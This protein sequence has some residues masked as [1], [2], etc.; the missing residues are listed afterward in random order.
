MKFFNKIFSKKGGQAIAEY[1]LV[2]LI[3][4][5]AAAAINT[6]YHSSENLIKELSQNIRNKNVANEKNSFYVPPNA[7]L[8]NT[9]GTE[10]VEDNPLIASGDKKTISTSPNSIVEPDQ[11]NQNENFVMKG[12]HNPIAYF[13]TNQPSTWDTLSVYDYS[14]DLDGGDASKLKRFWKFEK[15]SNVNSVDDNKNLECSHVKNCSPGSSGIWD[16]RSTTNATYKNFTALGGKNTLTYPSKRDAELLSQGYCYGTVHQCLPTNLS[17]GNYSIHLIVIDEDQNEAPEAI[18]TITVKSQRLKLQYVY[19]YGEEKIVGKKVVKD[20]GIKEVKLIDHQYALVTDLYGVK[21]PV[22]EMNMVRT[23]SNKTY[24]VK[25]EQKIKTCQVLVDPD[26][27][28]EKGE[29]TNCKIETVEQTKEVQ[30]GGSAGFDKDEGNLWKE[31]K[32]IAND[33][34]FYIYDKRSLFNKKFLGNNN[35]NNLNLTKATGDLDGKVT[36]GQYTNGQGLSS[37]KYNSLRGLTQPAADEIVWS[38]NKRS[39]SNMTLNNS[40]IDAK[41]LGTNFQTSQMSLYSSSPYYPYEDKNSNLANRVIGVNNTNYNGNSSV[42]TNSYADTSGTQD[43]F[44]HI[45]VKK[46]H[47]AISSIAY[48]RKCIKNCNSQN[49]T[50]VNKTPDVDIIQL[51]SSYYLLSQQP[52]TKNVEQE[53]SD[54]IYRDNTPDFSDGSSMYLLRTNIEQATSHDNN[55]SPDFVSIRLSLNDFYGYNPGANMDTVKLSGT[56]A[57]NAKTAFDAQ[58]TGEAAKA[59]R[60]PTN[61]NYGDGVGCN[62]CTEPNFNYDGKMQWT[63][64]RM[65]EGDTGSLNESFECSIGDDTSTVY[66]P[67]FSIS[68]KMDARTRQYNWVE[69]A[70]FDWVYEYSGSGNGSALKA[71]NGSKGNKTYKIRRANWHTIGRTLPEITMGKYNDPYVLATANNNPYASAPTD[72]RILKPTDPI[73]FN[74]NMN[75]KSIVTASDGKGVGEGAGKDGSGREDFWNIL[76][77]SISETRTDSTTATKDIDCPCGGSKWKT[78][79][80]TVKTTLTVSYTGLGDAISQVKTNHSSNTKTHGKCDSCKTE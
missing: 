60:Y 58:I 17:N 2:L 13:I 57:T 4:S 20:D 19:E 22:I 65:V 78:K 15:I 49:F 36:G 32:M 53:F 16:T 12:K 40:S 71:T 69:H 11:S 50:A 64:Y 5:A 56:N 75:D 73:R 7:L 70:S 1:V 37:S 10:A 59:N 30:G 45:S 52:Q 43:F 79:T 24:E 21:H 67:T 25:T 26:T 33:W 9:W 29:R 68:E 46:D 6:T 8:Y 80:C 77:G 72:N 34:I 66:Y 23:S 38:E 48:E 35:E 47:N 55:F 44:D 63:E 62:E 76:R 61:N 74:A 18:Q 41:N 31:E 42:G 14:Y 54:L 39:N 27:G 28:E 51:E 3:V